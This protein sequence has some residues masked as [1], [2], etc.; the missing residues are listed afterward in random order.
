MCTRHCV[1]PSSSPCQL[2]VLTARVKGK[3]EVVRCLYWGECFG[4]TS[5][6][7]TSA[8]MV[9]VNNECIMDPIHWYAPPYKEFEAK[10]IGDKLPGLAATIATCIAAHEASDLPWLTAVGWDVMMTD[11]GP[12][13]FFE[14]KMRRRGGEEEAK[15]RRRGGEKA[16][17]GGC[18]VERMWIEMIEGRG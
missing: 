12:G 11:D 2:D 9:D 16:K 15:K 14:G 4:E 5:H 6:T 10:R 3:V 13:V 8:Y 1:S 7:A 18:M 17:Q